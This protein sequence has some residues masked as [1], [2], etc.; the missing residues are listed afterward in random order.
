MNPATVSGAIDRWSEK[1]PGTVSPYLSKFCGRSKEKTPPGRG[2]VAGKDLAGGRRPEPS[3]YF[4]GARPGTL[5][6]GSAV[7]VAAGGGVAGA[8][9]TGVAGAAVAGVAG[10]SLLITAMT[11]SVMS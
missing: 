11:S 7:V 6:V 9:V 5:T 4:F 2:G 1:S 8:G 10:R 3:T